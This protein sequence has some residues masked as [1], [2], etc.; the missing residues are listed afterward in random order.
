MYWNHLLL[1]W[2]K[3]ELEYSII[4][5]ILESYLHDENPNFKILKNCLIGYFSTEEISE[6]EDATKL[7]T[8]VK[9]SF[10]EEV[11]HFVTL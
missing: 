11:F 4:I 9:P 2:P 10:S 1:N 3:N 5:M 7:S 8:V 6:T